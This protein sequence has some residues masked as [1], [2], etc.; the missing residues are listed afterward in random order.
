MTTKEWLNK[1]KTD[2]PDLNQFITKL[3]AFISDSGLNSP[4][5]E[6]A[7]ETGLK[8]IE[9]DLNKSFIPDQNAEN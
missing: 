4:N 7:V 8:N 1:T 6:S 5:F 3:E 9:S 2:N